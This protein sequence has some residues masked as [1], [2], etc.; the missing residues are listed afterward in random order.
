VLQRDRPRDVRRTLGQFW[1][2]DPIAELMVRWALHD[3]PGRFLDP[4]A[5]PLTFLRAARRTVGERRV[6]CVAFELDP[7][8]VRAARAVRPPG[9]CDVRA[10]D[11]L[12]ATA[13]FPGL[14]VVCNPPY[15]R[16][17]LLRDGVKEALV[18]RTAR[19]F[20]FRPSRFL[21]AYGWFLLR[22]LETTG[23]TSR[24]CFITPLE[25]L[26]SRS[27]LELFRALPEAL[28][29][30]RVI[31]FGPEF[32][33][34]PGVDATAAISCIDPQ[35]AAA[36][37]RALLVLREW[38]G[39]E[40]LRRW[41]EARAASPAPTGC[42]TVLPLEL[43]ERPSIV[44]DAAETSL[45]RQPLFRCARVVRGVATGANAFFLFDRARR[46]ASGLPA[47]LFR[48]VIARA[49]DATR[50]V[51]STADLEA[52]E[53]RG[54]PTWLL[55][56]PRGTVPT[57][58][59][60]RWLSAGEQSGLAQRPLLSRRRP[61]W[62]TEA[63][64]PPPILFTYLSRGDPRFVLNEAGAVALTTFLVLRPLPAPPG[65]PPADWL[66][67]L[68][69]ALN[70]PGTLASLARHG[71]SYGGATRKI[72]PRELERIDLPALDELPPPVLR[73]LARRARSWLGEPAR[74]PRRM[75]A[76]RWEDELRGE[77]AKLS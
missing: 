17:H 21:G 12:S 26:T 68:A 73:V 31:V 49:R 48:R 16:H 76:A 8:L 35:A 42:G 46:R 4:G 50:L 70:T 13:R 61:W 18:E 56:L 62:T 5:G 25:L 40:P 77:L 29:P 51:L 19:T 54:R 39:V 59:L 41:L 47:Q 64:D 14:P 28:W 44:P 57:G 10:E 33:A 36:G 22:A 72:E 55:A 75:A 66:A 2:P 15:S 52:L 60:A 67:C 58:A 45:H 3:E 20:G 11:F 34:F 65:V 30:R 27:G 53:R 23:G 37:K 24:L 63:R 6:S 74:E 38:P 1:T 69:A 9:A 43:G 71:R 32:D 7:D